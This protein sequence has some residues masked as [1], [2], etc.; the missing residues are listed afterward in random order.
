MKE[1]LIIESTFDLR[2]AFEAKGYSIS[3]RDN[4]FI[5]EGYYHDLGKI[6]VQFK[7]VFSELGHRSPIDMRVFHYINEADSPQENLYK[8]LA[9]TNQND[10]DTLMELL[11]TS[12]D[13]VNEVQAFIE[14]QPKASEPPQK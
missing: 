14:G 12:D 10:F 2:K 9:P 8:G 6:Q 7:T 3:E 11:F 5:A 4:E 13:F 1:K